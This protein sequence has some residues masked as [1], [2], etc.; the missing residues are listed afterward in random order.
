M[1]VRR[2]LSVCLTLAALAAVMLVAPERA[3]ARQEPPGARDHAMVPRMPNYLISEYEFNEFEA[4][5]FPVG[6]DREVSVEGKH[7]KFLYAIK[8]GTKPPSELQILRNYAN[9]FKAK[10]FKTEFYAEPGDGVFSLKTAQSE[11]WCRVRPGG[12]SGETYNIEIVEK[13][14]MEQSIELNS[15]ELAKA[16]DANGSVAIHGILFDTGKATIKPD[17]EKVLQTIGDVLKSNAALKLEI[18][19]HTDDV[20]AKAANQTLSQQRAE[21]VRQYLITK[22]GI[23]AAR[24]TSAGFGD[25]KPVAPNTT[26]D[27][28]AQ[29]RRVELVKK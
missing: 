4:G 1:S 24:L 27:G 11:I 15:S 21:S 25:T 8:E 18:Q 7:W 6:N 5:S 10:N 12:G 3:F 17:S 23:A 14:G 2:T 22:F 16:L 28:R 29:N 20:G 26:E 19:G 9:A 13:S